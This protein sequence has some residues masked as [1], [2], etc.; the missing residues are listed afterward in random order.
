MCLPSEAALQHARWRGH[1][2]RTNA[3]A[4]M[5][6]VHDVLRLT[7]VTKH[8]W[9]NTRTSTSTRLRIAAPILGGLRQMGIAYLC[10]C[11]LVSEI[12][13]L[14]TLVCVYC[15]DIVTHTERVGTQ[16]R[17]NKCLK[18]NTSAHKPFPDTPRHLFK[19][20]LTGLLACYIIRLSF[21]PYTLKHRCT[22]MR[23]LAYKACFCRPAIPATPE[24][25]TRGFHVQSPSELQGLFKASLGNLV[26]S[27]FKTK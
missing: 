4:T 19:T 21:R 10:V 1:R 22:H 3:D 7:Q 15:G 18:T 5:T 17:Q 2:A 13:V 25:E 27:C 6:Q 16:T 14:Y 24:A 26:R 11:L 23:S 8:R 12:F 20:T 9:A